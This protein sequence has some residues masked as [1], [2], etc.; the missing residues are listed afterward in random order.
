[1]SFFDIVMSGRAG[2]SDLAGVAIGGNVWMPVF[3]GLSGVLMALTP[4]VA[5]LRGADK[6]RK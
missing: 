6:N 2:N 4:I 5:Q 1:M 3:T